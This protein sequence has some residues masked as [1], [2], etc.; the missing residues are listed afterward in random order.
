MASEKK[1]GTNMCYFIMTG[2]FTFTFINMLRSIMQQEATDSQISHL[3][4][5]GFH[6]W[7]SS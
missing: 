7:N 4:L 2:K 6:T 3:D 5:L 1:N